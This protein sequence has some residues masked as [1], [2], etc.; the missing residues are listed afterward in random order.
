[1]S[2]TLTISLIC[3][4]IF[5]CILCS[6]Y[7]SAS[8]ISFTSVNTI[9]LEGEAEDGNK[10]AKRALKILEKYD[11]MLSAILIGNN[12]VNIAASSLGAVLVIL[13]AGDDSYA[14][15]ATVALTILIIIFGE[16][17]PKITAKKN[18]NHFV[19]FSGA[20]LRVL[21]I[22]FF[23]I[24][25]VVVF[26]IRLITKPMA[27]RLADEDEDTDESVEELQSIVETA[28]DEGVLDKDRSELVSAA[29]DFPEISAF[30]VMT[31]R[32]DVDAIDI[33]DSLEEIMELVS[34]TPYTR[35]PVYEGSIDHVIGILHMNH[36]LKAMAENE[37]TD[38]R[39]L[40]MPP[41][42]LYKTTKLPDVLEQLRNARQH[43]AIVTDEYSGTLGV[44]SMEDVME[45]I[46]GEIWDETDVIEEDVIR[47]SDNEV[48]VDGDMRIS[49]FLEIIDEDER[50]FDCDS[51]TL[52]GWMIESLG[53]FPEEG[54]VLTQENYTLKVVSMDERRV[55]KVRICFLQAETE[56][57]KGN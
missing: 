16:T 25:F 40:L 56:A 13:I 31:A 22:V 34:K 17:I 27:K 39:S 28:E 21:M 45:Q 7:F 24:I 42:F 52:G 6:A 12:L 51:D 20:I 36:F 4:G 5:L 14:W 18:A 9:R 26:L 53:H 2:T 10:R 43:L 57:E 23:P 15:V 38:I 44:I 29:I 54:E 35:I 50:N 55:D 33:E 19:L 48:E 32:V 49:D 1:M 30:E 41:C 46:V 8:E 3:L 37:K 47:V 11:D